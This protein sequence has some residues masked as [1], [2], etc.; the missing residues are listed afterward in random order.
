MLF[1]AKKNVGN[2][3]RRSCQL[4]NDSEAMNLSQDANIVRE[5]ML[6]RK[7]V[8]FSGSF[9][10]DCQEHSVPQ[11]LVMLIT[12]IIYGTKIKDKTSYLSQPT[13]SLSQLIMF[14]SCVPTSSTIF[15]HQAFRTKRNSTAIICWCIGT[16]ENKIKRSCEYTL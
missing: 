2:S 11:S 15:A 3:L 5:D 13:L 6:R 16:L 14:H 4:D 1:V 8:P 9:T 10:E 7:N 12:M